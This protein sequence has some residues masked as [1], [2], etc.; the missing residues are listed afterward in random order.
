GELRHRLR[1]IGLGRL[2]RIRLRRVLVVTALLVILRVRLRLARHFAWARAELGKGIILTDQP[3]KLGQWIVG[4]RGRTR[5]T[6]QGIAR[7]ETRGVVVRHTKPDFGTLGG[8][9]AVQAKVPA[10]APLHGPRHPAPSYRI[11]PGAPTPNILN[12]EARTV[13]TPWTSARR[14]T[15][16]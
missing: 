10:H 3:G 8:P 5:A 16:S 15:V 1:L 14:A 7:S 11:S 12:P 6:P 4:R 9:E 13:T 2:R